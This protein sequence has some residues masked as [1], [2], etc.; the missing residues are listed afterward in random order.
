MFILLWS[1][2]FM[3]SLGY[4]YPPHGCK[5][6]SMFYARSFIIFAFLLRSVIHLQLICVCVCVCCEIEHDSLFFQTE[7]LLSQHCQL[8]RFLFPPL[9]DFGA[10][11]KI[12]NADVGT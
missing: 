10:Q 3:P 2:V 7:I 9:N 6:I 4:I 5:D 8:N 12:L 11:A 1:V